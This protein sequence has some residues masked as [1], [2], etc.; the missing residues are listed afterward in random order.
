MKHLLWHEQCDAFVQML[1]RRSPAKRGLPM[2]GV[3]LLR[4]LLHW[5]P[6]SRPSAAAAL[7]HAYFTVDPGMQQTYRC[8]GGTASGKDAED[9]EGW[10]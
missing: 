5:N 7:R 1:A 3:R 10:C 2:L 4:R 9:L 8:P 6:T